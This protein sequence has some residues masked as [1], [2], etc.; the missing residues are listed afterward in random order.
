MAAADGDVV[1]NCPLNKTIINK[2]D[3]GDHQMRKYILTSLLTVLLVGMSACTDE[4]GK[5]EVRAMAGQA[6][7]LIRGLYTFGHEV[8]AL[9]P[10]G[11]DEALWVIDKTKMLGQLYGKLDEAGQGGVQIFVIFNGNIGPAPADGFGAEYAGSVTVEEILYAAFEGHRCDFDL[12]GFVYRASGN[13]PFWLVEVLSDRM[14]LIRPGFP[15]LVW[16]GLTMETTGNG[17]VWRGS[18]G[19]FP[20]ALTIGPG[21]AY[22]SMSGA[23]FHQK[24]S[25]DLDGQIFKGSAMRGLASPE[26]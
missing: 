5:Q 4:G 25:F 7:E 26:S 21:P 19:E 8:R 23:Y 22:D 10:C 11:E 3:Q 2:A 9:R 17:V 18:G 13:E 20:A 15:D 14:R 6:P 24:A 12:A 1:I 16:P